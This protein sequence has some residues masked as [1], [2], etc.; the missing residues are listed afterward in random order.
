MPVPAPA[1]PAMPPTG[2]PPVGSSP[3]TAPVPN[4]GLEAAGMAKLSLI[5]R[6]MELIVPLL[7]A[8]TEAGRDVL[9]ALTSLSKHVPPGAVSPGVEQS[10]MNQVQMKMK[11]QTPQLAQMR[12]AIAQQKPEGTAPP[13]AA[14]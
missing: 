14:A 6:Q 10:A 13:A 3:A 1:I 4:K 7:G 5:I 8:G 11:Q 2:Q 9:K 12:A